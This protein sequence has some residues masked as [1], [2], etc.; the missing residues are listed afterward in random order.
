LSIHLYYM[1]LYHSTQTLTTLSL[2]G[3]RIGE[4]GAEHLVKALQHNT[5]RLFLYLLYLICMCTISHRHSPQYIFTVSVSVLQKY[6][7]SLKKWI[8]IRWKLNFGKDKLKFC[9]VFIFH[10]FSNNIIRISW[11]F[12][13]LESMWYV[14][15]CSL[16]LLLEI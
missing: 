10:L 8:L 16:K 11:F 4:K 13:I 14:S 5:V 7:I 6:K 12:S 9:I 2:A 3:N 15:Y 1:Q